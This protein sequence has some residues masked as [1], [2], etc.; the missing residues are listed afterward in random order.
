MMHKI[1]KSNSPISTVILHISIL[2]WTRK[3]KLE[4]PLNI[5]KFPWSEKKKKKK[6]VSFR[7]LQLLNWPNKSATFSLFKLHDTFHSRGVQRVNDG[8]SFRYLKLWLALSKGSRDLRRVRHVLVVAKSINC[9]AL[10]VLP[11]IIVWKLTSSPQKW[12]KKR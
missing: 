10:R 4:K 1:I 5:I 9:S 11:Y 3:I 12:P 2:Y 6:K 7:K 8:L